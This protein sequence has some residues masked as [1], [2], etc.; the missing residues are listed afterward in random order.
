MRCLSSEPLRRFSPIIHRQLELRRAVLCSRRQ[1][2]TP[3]SS[4]WRGWRERPLVYNN[5]IIIVSYIILDRLPTWATLSACS[6]VIPGRSRRRQF[7]ASVQRWH[8]L[9]RCYT[10]PSRL[11]LCASPS[12]SLVSCPECVNFIAHFAHFHESSEAS[13]PASVTDA[14]FVFLSVARLLLVLFLFDVITQNRVRER[15][16]HNNHLLCLS[17]VALLAATSKQL[18]QF[19]KRR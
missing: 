12:L 10:S 13:L 16:T 7:D 4:G 11:G 19:V 2:N 3:R 9:A 17:F 5:I 6:K 18:S 1:D 14:S 15:K 8:P